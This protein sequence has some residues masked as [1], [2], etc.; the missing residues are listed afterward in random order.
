[1]LITY[2]KEVTIEVDAETFEDAIAQVQAME[3]DLEFSIAFYDV[4]DKGEYHV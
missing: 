4:S 2:T 3:S 1:M